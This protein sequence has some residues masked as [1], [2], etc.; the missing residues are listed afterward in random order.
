MNFP[1]AWRKMHRVPA[2]IHCI[3]VATEPHGGNG[4]VC[5]DCGRA[6]IDPCRIMKQLHR[7][8]GAPQSHKRAC[9]P[10]ACH[11]AARIEPRSLAEFT[12]GVGVAAEAVQG[13]AA[14]YVHRTYLGLLLRGPTASV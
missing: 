13:E 11:V 7:L 9:A 6:G 1:V 2:H 12:Q 10:C 4:Q 14:H 5:V 3:I 8:V